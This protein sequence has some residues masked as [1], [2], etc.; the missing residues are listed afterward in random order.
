VRLS[1]QTSWPVPYLKSQTIQAI[2]ERFAVDFFLSDL[3]CER[4]VAAAR[5]ALE[6]TQ[7]HGLGESGAATL[8]D[9]TFPLMEV[10]TCEALYGEAGSALL[11]ALLE[12]VQSQIE[13][14]CG[15]VRPA[16]AL[17]NWIR[18]NDAPV[19]SGTTPPC[20]SSDG[21]NRQPD[22]R[23]STP[24]QHGSAFGGYTVPHVDRANRPEYDISCIMYLNTHDEDFQGV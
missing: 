22:Q 20:D 21:R 5:R 15:P 14:K 8:E 19:A 2:D 9:A 18:G 7:A 16:G 4:A 17:L 11:W 1:K 10:D 13:A 23:L 12:R 6:L 24:G 3:E